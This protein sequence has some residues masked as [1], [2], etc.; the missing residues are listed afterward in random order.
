MSSWTS[1]P[2]FVAL[3]VTDVAFPESEGFVEK[4]EMKEFAGKTVTTGNVVNSVCSPPNKCERGQSLI[5]VL[6]KQKLQ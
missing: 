6:K 1:R 2:L 5:A 4:V 3:Y